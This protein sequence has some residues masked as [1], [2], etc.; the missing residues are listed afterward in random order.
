MDQ[1]RTQISQ[2]SLQCGELTPPWRTVDQ[3]GTQIS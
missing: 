3:K 1:K 2:P